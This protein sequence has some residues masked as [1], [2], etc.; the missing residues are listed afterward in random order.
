MVAKDIHLKNQSKVSPDN[1]D[2]ICEFEGSRRKTF[3]AIQN[4]PFLM[5]MVA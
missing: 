3:G 1:I 2:R 4:H 5:K